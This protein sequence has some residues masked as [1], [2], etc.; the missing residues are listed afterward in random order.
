MKSLYWKAVV[1]L[2]MIFIFPPIGKTTLR[3]QWAS[4]RLEKQIPIHYWAYKVEP[5]WF[6]EIGKDKDG[7]DGFLEEYRLAEDPDRLA[8]STHVAVFASRERHAF[9]VKSQ[10]GKRNIPKKKIKQGDVVYSPHVLGLYLTRREGKYG[11]MTSKG[12]IVVMPVYE[13]MAFLYTYTPEWGTTLLPMLIVYKGGKYA[14][15]DPSGFLVSRFCD[16]EAE[17]P[18]AYIV[19]KANEF[20]ITDT[21][22]PERLWGF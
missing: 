1:V 12:N 21:V 17:I 20:K 4:I 5:W 11:L 9:A 19:G 8:D 15:M 2:A 22:L 7:L 6:S 14:L 16:T 13:D 18:S 10:S 3:A